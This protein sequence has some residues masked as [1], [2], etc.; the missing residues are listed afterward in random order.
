MGAPQDRIR[1]ESRSLT[2]DDLDSKDIEAYASRNEFDGVDEKRIEGHVRETGLT[3]EYSASQGLV[4][5]LT[6]QQQ[7]S[8]LFSKYIIVFHAFIWMVMTG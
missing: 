6:L 3:P 5:E 7:A 2:P 8:L 4:E 1:T